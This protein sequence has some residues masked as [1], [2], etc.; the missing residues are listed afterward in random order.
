MAKSFIFS[1]QG[2]AGILLVASSIIFLV[3]GLLFTGRVIWNWPAGQSPIYLRWERGLV[4]ADILLALLGLMLL[5]KLLEEAGD[6]I[7]APSGLLLFLSGTVLIIVAET[8]FISQ[9]RKEYATV[10]V[11]VI[12]AFLGQAAFGAA[13]LRTGFLPAWVGWATIAWN[14]AWL[15]ILPIAR[16]QDIYYP[17][18]HYV[19]PLVIGIALL[20][21]R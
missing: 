1:E 8:L 4:I 14:L 19:A 11:S 20:I 10:V 2:L 17:W 7:L 15:V 18:L 9:G 16:P 5:G 12:L 13:I 6:R 3:V 21:K